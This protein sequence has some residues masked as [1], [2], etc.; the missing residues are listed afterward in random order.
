MEEVSSK[1]QVF[2]DTGMNPV[3]INTLIDS[4]KRKIDKQLRADIITQLL[5]TKTY[6]QISEETGIHD[7]TLRTWKRNAEDK[8]P[9]Q[10]HITY[11]KIIK[12][13]NEIKV[14][15]ANKPLLESIEILIAKKLEEYEK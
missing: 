8:R 1:K 7:N 10:S 11:E 13:F 6:V 3:Y 2:C 14:N 15:R 4:T 9:T 5:K 12:F